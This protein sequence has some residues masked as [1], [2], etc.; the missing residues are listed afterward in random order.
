MQVD[1]WVILVYNILETLEA[2][3][4]YIGSLVP[5]ISRNPG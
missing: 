1:F 2:V 3:N 5:L 4:E